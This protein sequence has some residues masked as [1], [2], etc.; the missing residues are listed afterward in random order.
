[1]SI[2]SDK[3]KGFSE[4]LYQLD[5]GSIEDES[6]FEEAFFAELR[7]VR[8]SW[9]VEG[10]VE[11]FIR[12]QSQYALK[13]LLRL[14]DSSSTKLLERL[15][16]A[17]HSEKRLV[18]LFL[19]GML[20][21]NDVP[22]IHRLINDPLFLSIL[23]LLEFEEDL[24]VLMATLVVVTVVLPSVPSDILPFLE[25][26]FR[27]FCRLAEFLTNKYAG[28]IPDVLLLQLKVGIHAY[29]H[30][31]YTMYPCNLIAFLRLRYFKPSQM[32]GSGGQSNIDFEAIVAPFMNHLRIHPH[33]II[34][35]A[36]GERS[37]ENW[38]RHEPHDILVSCEKL[39]TTPK[40][41][42]AW[43]TD[44]LGYLGHVMTFGAGDGVA[45][46]AAATSAVSTA[47]GGG[48]GP[49]M[50]GR[51]S[52]SAEYTHPAA[53][54]AASRRL[55]LHR[56]SY[57]SRHNI[58]EATTTT[59]S[60][61]VNSSRS[62]DTA[63]AEPP[64]RRHT[65]SSDVLAEST[66]TM[67][68]PCTPLSN[69][70]VQSLS[71][72]VSTATGHHATLVSSG[73]TLTDSMNAADAK[74]SSK[75]DCLP[76]P[77][78]DTSGVWSPSNVVGLAT[79]PSSLPSE[80][81]DPRARQRSVSD[82]KH[83][84]KRHHDRR[85]L[86]DSDSRGKG[87][88]SF[89][90]F[91]GN[92]LGMMKTRDGGHSP[93]PNEQQEQ[94][95]VRHDSLDSPSAV[96]DDSRTSQPGHATRDDLATLSPC[97]E[98]A[99]GISIADL[100]QLPGAARSAFAAAGKAQDDI[101]GTPLLCRSVSDSFQRHDSVTPTPASLGE[102]A[103]VGDRQEG[104]EKSESVAEAAFEP[105]THTTAMA[106][107]LS[108]QAQRISS[109]KMKFS[110]GSEV[111]EVPLNPKGR[112]HSYHAG[113]SALSFVDCSLM[114]KFDEALKDEGE[115]GD[116][117]DILCGGPV[118][119]TD[120]MDSTGNSTKESLSEWTSARS[121]LQA[122]SSSCSSSF[123]PTSS[124][125]SCLTSRS[126]QFA[127]G[128]AV[129][130]AVPLD[131]LR[132]STSTE[133]GSSV[134]RSWPSKRGNMTAALSTDTYYQQAKP[135]VVPMTQVLVRSENA[136]SWPSL[137]AGMH[138]P[139]HDHHVLSSLDGS[140][141]T[142]DN[143]CVASASSGTCCFTALPSSST[144][145]CGPCPVHSAA[146]AMRRDMKAAQLSSQSSTTV[147]GG[148]SR[149]TSN[150][151]LLSTGTHLPRALPATVPQ[152]MASSASGSSTVSLCQDESAHR[153]PASDASPTA[154][155]PSSL[156]AAAAARGHHDLVEPCSHASCCHTRSAPMAML[157]V[158]DDHMVLGAAL[159]NSSASDLPVSYQ[160]G[161]DWSHYGE[162]PHS[163]EIAILQSKVLMLQ[164]QLL[165]ERHQRLQHAQRHREMQ[166][167][168]FMVHAVEEE[169]HAVKDQLRLQEEEVLKLM[170]TVEQRRR[171]NRD[172]VAT[173][174]RREKVLHNNI[175]TLESNSQ[176][177]REQCMAQQGQVSQLTAEAGNLQN[178]LQMLR[179]EHSAMR[180]D[181][182]N[183]V[184]LVDKGR[185]LQQQVNELRRE[186]IHVTMRAQSL[187]DQQFNTY[188]K[189]IHMARL[190]QQLDLVTGEFNASKEG[191]LWLTNQRDAF[192]RKIADME[193]ELAQKDVAIDQMKATLLRQQRT[194]EGKERIAEE[195]IQS[196]TK[197]NERLDQQI[198]I[199]DGRLRLH[200]RQLITVDVCKTADMSAAMEMTSESEDA[201]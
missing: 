140:S 201:A 123:S 93:E 138:H 27:V 21:S 146:A 113:W 19:L 59:T 199:L 149:S 167:K 182:M 101:Q 18:G 180:L 176:S 86:E 73:G 114:E 89:L 187:Q 78:S 43:V 60:T 23:D 90:S 195:A 11:H 179:A 126:E 142:S 183:S 159:H 156:L 72:S 65:F 41:I 66:E 155:S 8:D 50:S 67:G 36:D 141:V 158:V 133:G 5:K 131:V 127:A 175:R 200:Q 109:P 79:P 51:G 75:L 94:R 172:L 68:S 30:R 26:L 9:L 7:D 163:D 115:E 84:K 125:L 145:R 58:T 120:S 57:L 116:E 55:A 191:S 181:L 69:E 143:T 157:D 1:M 99:S 106:T 118:R 166:S 25:S 24:P 103:G 151:M 102:A 112:H 88:K 196:L 28:N 35:S 77:A 150:C 108:T 95:R 160:P 110:T 117:S 97:K 169:L 192:H 96:L 83:D 64:V 48:G 22:W 10:V 52:S 98:S 153:R 152:A 37:Q 54:V 92:L 119:W 154:R 185:Q 197:T 137:P 168:L 104:D 20:V 85:G 147:G 144:L 14:P 44:Y 105:F 136:S 162:S 190:Q 16:V 129:N 42:D 29:F 164:S 189:D 32:P 80:G 174:H 71:A 161:C 4:L 74:K 13:L 91:V 82:V 39:A 128:A 2:T 173:H 46:S 178:E 184:P 47:A 12:T 194:A 148:V 170:Q 122:S 193:K 3:R 130:V 63:T 33:I 188:N 40:E 87:Q 31:L 139:G 81:I 186:L 198:Y 56:L 15:D 62:T 165:L 70:E 38:R 45:T 6:E 107:A 76:P 17:L 171:E 100:P 135:A 49:A 111:G 34:S 134:S 53:S 177:V 132:S 124:F 121:L 61:Q